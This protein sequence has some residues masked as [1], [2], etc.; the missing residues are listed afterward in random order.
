MSTPRS[1]T[2]IGL[3]SGT[4]LD[5]VDLACCRFEEGPD[6]WQFS[7]E[8]AETVPYDEKW[9]ARLR[10]LDE[11]DA[12]A[13]A[14]TNVYFGHHLGRI[15]ADFIVRHG[16]QPDFVASHGQTI[17]HQPGRNFTAQIGDGETMASYLPCPLVTNFR[18]KDVALGG[19]GAPLVPFGERLLFPGHQLFLNLGGIANLSYGALAFDVCPCNMALNW[20][21]LQADPPLPYD[22][23][24][25]I[26]RSGK[27]DPG[28]QAALGSLEF[29]RQAPPKSLGAE[30]Y[31]QHVLPLLSNDEIS[32]ADRMA[33]MVI[34]IA[35]QVAAAAKQVGA[36][37]QEIL[38]S[39]GGAHNTTL[40]AVLDIMLG[41]IGIRP[42]AIARDVIDYKEALIF[43]FLGL[44]TLLGRPNALASVTGARMDVCGGSIHLPPGGWH[45]SLL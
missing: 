17:F 11:Q 10:C 33:T 32:I 38:I 30:W 14:K 43:A 26:A 44:Q 34:H 21:A 2:G 9:Y 13:Y 40:M 31:A 3:M 45:K 36:R 39:G 4:S 29:Y 24:G 22:D 20:L 1:Y 15:L 18:N 42:A 8:C 37:D 25:R 5:G 28:L 16:L 12:A 41:R 19:Q 23:D 6:G 7:L 27:P 35:R